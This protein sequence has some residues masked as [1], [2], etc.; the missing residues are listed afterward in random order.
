MGLRAITVGYSDPEINDAAEQNNGNCLT[1]PSLIELKA[2][3]RA[4]YHWSCRN[5][6]IAKNG[7]NVTTA[8]LKLARAYTKKENM[9]PTQQPF[10]SFDDWFI[11]QQQ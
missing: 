6:K 7:S 2:L 1:R 3:S 4:Q 10:F 9:V 5:G 8:A 11:D